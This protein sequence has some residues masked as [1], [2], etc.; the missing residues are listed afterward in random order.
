VR[1][2]AASVVLAGLFAISTAC[3]SSSGRSDGATSE[4][5][6]IVT[7]TTQLTD[8]ARIVGGTDVTVYGVL[9]ANVDPHD[10]EP[11]PADVD[12]LANAD[13]IVKNGVGLEAWF[14][15]TIASAEPEGEIVDAS[16]GVTLRAHDPHIWLDPDNAAIMATN[17]ERALE[18]ADPAHAGEFQTNL[19]AFT[20]QLD[21]LDTA[22]RSA[23]DK[24]TNKKVVT[25]HDALGYFAD[26]YGLEL[27]GSI[28]PSSDTSAQLSAQDIAG[29][30]A[31]I[32]ATGTKAVFSESSL[33]PDT[34]KAIGSEA[35]VKVVAGEDSL[36]LD[37]L[38]PA[39]SDGD[40]Y[41]K[42]EAH[43]TKV[44]VDNLS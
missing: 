4:G 1:R 15:D 5:V 23:L 22:N 25:N 13:V 26:H 20:S 8:F 30:V 33:P 38:G 36:Y 6:A 27:V 29:I 12:M 28:I 9:K 16:Q 44:I 14:D 35:G 39:G 21:A 42:M 40:T 7:T 41:L 31:K 17:I 32:K 43:N 10:Y 24:L 11:S 34:A 18:K 3:S 19:A 37:T 2:T